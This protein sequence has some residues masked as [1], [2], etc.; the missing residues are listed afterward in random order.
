MICYNEKGRVKKVLNIDENVKG[1]K[2]TQKLQL[3]ASTSYVNI[4]VNAI[5]GENVKCTYGKLP[6]KYKL[7]P[8]YLLEGLTLVFVLIAIRLCVAK[9][10]GDVFYE[11]YL[12]NKNFNMI[13]LIIFIVMIIIYSVVGIIIFRKNKMKD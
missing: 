9:I 12:K 11:D 5:N 3:V 8:F 10:V 7:F 1:K 13:Y 4:V 6:H 2:Y